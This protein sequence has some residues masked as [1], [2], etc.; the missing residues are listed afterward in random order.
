[1]NT[2]LTPQSNPI[3]NLEM[4]KTMKFGDNELSVD[5][6]ANTNKPYKHISLLPN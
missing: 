4:A 1:M 3:K 2:L 5:T 6:T